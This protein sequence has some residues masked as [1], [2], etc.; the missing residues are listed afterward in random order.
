MKR[1]T[2][3]LTV[4]LI[5][6]L[7]AIPCAFSASNPRVNIETSKGNIVVELFPDKA[8]K[9]VDNFL[10]Y[11][12]GAFYDG[13]IFHRVIKGF[14]IQSGGYDADGKPRKTLKPIPN[15]STNG[16]LNKKWTIAMAR[17]ANPDS[18]TSQFFINTGNNKSLDPHGGKKGY[19]VFGKVVEGLN[20]VK[21]IEKVEVGPDMYLGKHRPDDDV[22]IIKA[23]LIKSQPKK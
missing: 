15:E 7:S 13:L 9:T 14:M 19:T 16:L 23:R 20:V 18:A 22:F 10:A 5:G 8:P 1:S 17:T 4:L 2:Q 11:V 12:Q 6:M 21:S 3:I